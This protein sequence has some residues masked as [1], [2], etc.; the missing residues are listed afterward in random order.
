MMDSLCRNRKLGDSFIPCV[1]IQNDVTKNFT[2]VM[3]AI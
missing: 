3:S 1:A 2:V